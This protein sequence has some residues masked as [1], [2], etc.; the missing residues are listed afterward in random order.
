MAVPYWILDRSRPAIL[1]KGVVRVRLTDGREAKS[2]VLRQT[3]EA[4]EFLETSAYAEGPDA[5]FVDL[6]WYWA[7]ER[8]NSIPGWIPANETL[9][10]ADVE[11]FNSLLEQDR[12]AGKSPLWT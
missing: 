10:L 7:G 5:L 4:K 8:R 11:T 1:D 12:K 9:S 3:Q 2:V 6:V